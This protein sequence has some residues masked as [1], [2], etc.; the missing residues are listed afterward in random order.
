[1]DDGMTGGLYK[2]D[3]RGNGLWVETDTGLT[4]NRVH[5]LAPQN[6][7]PS[8]A[9]TKTGLYRSTDGG[10]TWQSTTLN[11]GLVTSI[12]I[13]PSSAATVYAAT[14]G[15]GVYESTDSG[16]TWSAINN[17]MGSLNVR[18][19]VF[20]PT[21]STTLYAGTSNGIYKTTDGG[22]T[23]NSAGSGL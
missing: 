13:S 6:S 7:A 2:F 14:D 9:G 19:I 23:W 22:V 1:M 4:D 17:G 18:S 20:D 11:T 3:D 12:L 8:Y 16:V 10:H 15:N 5:A 21:V